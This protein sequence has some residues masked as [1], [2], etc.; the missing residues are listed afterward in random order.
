MVDTMHVL[1]EQLYSIRKY[2]KDVVSKVKGDKVTKGEMKKISK[3]Y[4]L[5]NNA[6]KYAK[7]QYNK[8]DTPSGEYK[9]D[10]TK[11][12]DYMSKVKKS[13]EDVINNE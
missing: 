12:N 2:L 4:S 3:T 13:L 6:M 5:L 7:S 10:L 11:A 9:D 1:N 8:V